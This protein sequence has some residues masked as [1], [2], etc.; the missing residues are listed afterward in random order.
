MSA[1]L[2]DA[3]IQAQSLILQLFAIS[4]RSKRGHEVLRQLARL[5]NSSLC[6]YLLFNVIRPWAQ[7][8]PI[9]VKVMISN[10]LWFIRVILNVSIISTAL[11]ELLVTLLIESLRATTT[12]T[13]SKQHTLPI[14]TTTSESIND[15]E[16]WLRL[17][18]DGHYIRQALLLGNGSCHNAQNAFLSNALAQGP[19]AGA[20][21]YDCNTNPHASRVHLQIAQSLAYMSAISATAPM[22]TI[23]TLMTQGGLFPGLQLYYVDTYGAGRVCVYVSKQSEYAVICFADSELSSMLRLYGSSCLQTTTA[24]LKQEMLSSCGKNNRLWRYELQPNSPIPWRP[25]GC[26]VLQFVEYFLRDNSKRKLYVTGHGLGGAL[27][28]LF[29]AHL[30]QRPGIELE[31]T[32]ILTFGAPPVTA[33]VD[34]RDWYDSTATQPTWRFAHGNEYPPVAQPPLPWPQRFHVGTGINVH[35]LLTNSFSRQTK[36]DRKAAAYLDEFDRRKLQLPFS[37]W[38]DYNPLSTLRVLQR[39][40]AQSKDRQAL[41]EGSLGTIQLHK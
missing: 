41:E 19:V 34:F 37:F 32:A 6:H 20:R 16:L 23:R 9:A 38:L 31:S 13:A 27:A 29:G 28:T 15:L 36:G 3:L 40:L 8:L 18:Q 33:S 5:F 17:G 35:E 26:T 10:Y 25:D 21:F 30:R 12:T 1:I 22:E 14:K 39:L 24:T 11:R 4:L 7:R 2:R